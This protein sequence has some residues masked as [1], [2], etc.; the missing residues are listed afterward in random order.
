MSA[1]GDARERVCRLIEAAR[2]IRDPAS[3]LGRRARRDLVQST[4]LSAEGVEL[5]LRECLETAPTDAELSELLSS[6]GPAARAHVIL[7]ANVFVAAH[8]AI[9]LAL[10]SSA[11]VAVKPSRREPHFARLLVLAAP[12][13]FEVVP[14]IRPEAGDALWAYGGDE[15]LDALATRFSATRVSLFARGP[16]FGAAVV[17]RAK[18]TREAAR[19]LAADIVPFEQRGCLSPAIALVAGDAADALGFAKLLSSE[20]EAFARDVPAGT[21]DANELADVARYRDA[22]SYAGTVIP[23]GPGWVAV[24][25]EHRLVPAPAGRN[26]TVVATSDPARDLLPYAR[27]I[28]ALGVAASADLRTSLAAAFPDARVSDLGRMQRPPFDGPADRR[29]F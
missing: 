1:G 22:F 17:D 15:T 13:L 25:E 27:Q 24:P 8:R 9:A 26:L 29:P 10:A 2:V 19:A 28:T 4:D 23:A 3:D 14:E 5:A 16:G 6:V 21:L 11:S 18:A 12:G 20:L 7:P